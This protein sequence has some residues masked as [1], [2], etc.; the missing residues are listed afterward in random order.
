MDILLWLLLPV[1]AATGWWS[2]HRQTRRQGGEKKGHPEGG[3]IKGLNFL[4]NEQPDKALDLFI[5]LLEV[6]DETID[7]HLLLGGLFRKRGEVER[8]IRIHQNLIAR[9]YLR[10]QDRATAML[11]LGKD[12]MHAGLLDRAEGLYKEI[13]ETGYYKIEAGR[14]LQRIYEQEK[15]W[16]AAIEY[17]SLVDAKGD[18][19]RAAVR[20]HYWCELAEKALAQGRDRAAY[21]HAKQALATDPNSVRASL[22]LGDLAVHNGN[23]KEAEKNYLRILRQDEKFLPEA[24][25][26][27][28][29]IYRQTGQWRTYKKILGKMRDEN[30]KIELLI[31]YARSMVES[32]AAEEARE[33]LLRALEDHKDSLYLLRDYLRLEQS[34]IAPGAN[35]TPDI[36]LQMIDSYLTRSPT[37]CCENCG[38]GSKNLYWQCPGCHQW[39]MVKPARDHSF[40]RSK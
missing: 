29:G 28:D 14:Q 33:F 7:T 15:D 8:A 18:S 40:K 16:K 34:K 9:P 35:K 39:G 13:L 30:N 25:P 1:A 20:A 12:Y 3:Y 10:G 6:D 27:L 4:L 36:V 23:L 21:A 31:H 22:L 17:S 38:F 5:D 11:E 24:L 32:G 26:K 2:G 19:G 37:F